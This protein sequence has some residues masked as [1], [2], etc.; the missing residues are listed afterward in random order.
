VADITA[1]QV[2]ALRESTGVGMMECKNALQEADGDIKKA[3]ALLREKGAAK[4][5]KRADRATSEGLIQAKVSDDLQTTALVE[6]NIETDFAARNDQFIALT[7]TICE[8]ALASGADTLEALLAAKPV[9][10]DSE[11]VKEAIAD[12]QTVIGE[13]MGIGHCVYLAVPDG[14]AG[15][16]H[17]YIHPPGKVGVAIRLACENDAV[18]ANDATK[19]LAHELC[20]QIAFSNP[21]SIDSSAIAADVIASEKE[22]YKNAAIKDGKPEKIIDKIVEGRLKGFFKE[23]CLIEQGYVKEEK[24]TVQALIEQTAKTAGGKIEVAAFTRYQLGNA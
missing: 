5:V 13:N 3:T 22:I 9:A 2:K 15:L 4:A 20:L 18:A 19:E 12:T 6:M 10:G 1:A 8:T 21:L 16:V 17:T 11:T 14:E 24:Q 23:S 7:N